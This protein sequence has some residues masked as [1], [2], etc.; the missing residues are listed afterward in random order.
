MDG[1]LPPN[2][3]SDM[4]LVAA[5]PGIIAGRFTGIAEKILDELP[6]WYSGETNRYSQVFWTENHYIMYA[7]SA[8]VLSR[9]V[10][11][12]EDL[13][14]R[15]RLDVFL[16]L[17]GSVGMAEFLSPVYYPFTIASLLNLY[18][19]SGD[20]AL[21]EKADRM[22]KMMASQIL[23]V[24]LP[25][26]KMISPS[27]RSYERHRLVSNG[28]H[29]HQFVNFLLGLPVGGS[30]D[31]ALHNTLSA[32]TWRYEPRGRQVSKMSLT[33]PLTTLID[34]LDR[35]VGRDHLDI[36]VS[37]LWGYGVYVAPGATLRRM[38]V[39]FMDDKGLW[40]HPHFR[41]LRTTRRVLACCPSFWIGL[42]ADSFL[43]R[44]YVEGLRLTGA[45]LRIFREGRV[46]L[47]SL[48]DYNGGLPCFQQWPWMVN[49]AGVVIWC[50]FG[51]PSSSQGLSE[52]SSA[53]VIPAISH[54][55]NVLV[56]N[57]NAR[58]LTVRLTNLRTRPF[59][60]WPVEEMDGA[61]VTATGWFVGLKDT[62]IMGY[63]I[64]HNRVCVA[65]RDLATSGTTAETFEAHLD[66]LDNF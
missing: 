28:Q 39:S 24:S 10:G 3:K 31:Q 4:A 55:G 57:Y 48:A 5:I 64:R 26:G 2:E 41:S 54:R 46:I 15:R 9:F 13:V 58:H 44:P 34:A 38:V 27:A 21:K 36:Y 20:D 60:R 19:H 47:S 17:K 61:W 45:S 14:L 42:A 12:E 49:L 8:Y 25:D 18:D 1:I 35:I 53:N 32:T 22:L 7:S 23:A 66:S 6:F 37:L 59:F 62:A 52:T 65:V 33:S 43:L 63:R 11:R 56:A 16:D 50:G 40:D 51:D 29:I 30:A